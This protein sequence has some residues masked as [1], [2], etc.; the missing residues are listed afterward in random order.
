MSRGGLHQGL[1]NAGPW[2]DAGGGSKGQEITRLLGRC[3]HKEPATHGSRNHARPHHAR[4]APTLRVRKEDF[5]AGTER[6]KRVQ[7]LK[8]TRADVAQLALNGDGFAVR[9][10]ELDFSRGWAARFCPSLDTRPLRG[11]FKRGHSR[12]HS[13]PHKSSTC[14]SGCAERCPEAPPL[15]GAASPFAKAPRG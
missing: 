15:C 2:D 4:S 11:A 3:Q 7:N 8:A 12:A 1:G 13:S 6:S 5:L 10:G 9:D 14:A